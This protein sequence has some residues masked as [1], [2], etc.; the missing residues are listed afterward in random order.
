M[1]PED[2]WPRA[3]R[4]FLKELDVN[5]ETTKRWIGGLALATMLLAPGVAGAETPRKVRE[6][7]ADFHRQWVAAGRPAP[8]SSEPQWGDDQ[9]EVYNA[10]AYDFQANTSTDRIMDDG[11]G[12][13]YFGAPGV[14]YMAAPVRLP[15]GVEISAIRTSHCAPNDGDLIVALYDNGAGGAGG[16]GGAIVAGPIA[17]TDD[18]GGLVVGIQPYTYAASDGHPLYLVMYF[19]GGQ[20]D[21]SAKFNNIALKYRHRVSP[22]PAQASYSDVPTTD[23]GFQYIEALAGSGITG[24]CGGGKF[25]PDQPVNRRQ[26]A[27]F[28]AKALGLHWEE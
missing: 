22:A 24:G 13:R 17:M 10:H 9:Y 25:C 20:T 12:Y 15:A 7:L 16:G 4:P 8:V 1:G 19:A 21:G 26:M 11:N 27:I 6:Q 18:C 28:L 14:P 23:F 3:S 5:N 2:G